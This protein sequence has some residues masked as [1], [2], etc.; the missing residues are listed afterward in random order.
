M[1]ISIERSNIPRPGMA[2]RVLLFFNYCINSLNKCFSLVLSYC[3]YIICFFGYN[4]T[5]LA[6]GKGK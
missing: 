2:H 5:L 3:I 4:Y 6:R 1:A